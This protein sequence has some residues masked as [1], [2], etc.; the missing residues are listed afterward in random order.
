N[1]SLLKLAIPLCTA[2]MAVHCIVPPHPAALFVT[3]EL[4]ADMGTV[5]VAGLAVGLLA[6][7]VG[8]P[9]FLKVLGE[10]L[11]FKTVPEAFSDMEIRQEKDLPSLGATLFTVLLPIV[12]ML[13]KTAAELNMEKG[14]SVYIALQFIGNP[15]T[16]MFIAAFVAYYILGIRRN[17]GMSTLL[18]KTEDSFSSIANILLIIGAG[19]AFNGILKGS[20]LSDSLAVILSN[21]DMHPILL[22]WLVAIILHAAVGS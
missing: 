12:L 19:G 20:G 9:L 13:I 14:T 16:A 11:P 15:I 6:S 18:K 1:T 3:N 10:R 22:A 2:L 8:G 7:L 4:G 5:I 17:M 21:L